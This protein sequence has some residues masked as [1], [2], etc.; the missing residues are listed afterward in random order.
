MPNDSRPPVVPAGLQQV[1]IPMN[2]TRAERM[3][4][5][6]FVLGAVALVANSLTGAG[7][8]PK[9]GMQICGWLAGVCTG[10]SWYLARKTPSIASLQA[11][12]A[13]G[14]EGNDGKSKTGGAG[15]SDPAG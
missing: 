7:F 5:T 11:V 8:I 6:A 10:L 4:W 14:K 13:N 9:I 12:R 15:G 3:A 2:P 1:E